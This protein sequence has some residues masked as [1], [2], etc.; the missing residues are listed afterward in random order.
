[1][2]DGP[3]M[4]NIEQLKDTIQQIKKIQNVLKK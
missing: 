2:S 1:L 3:N 4:L